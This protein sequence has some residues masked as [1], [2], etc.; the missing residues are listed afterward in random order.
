MRKY[1]IGL[2]VLLILAFA[3][4]SNA[5][6]SSA[7]KE[8]QYEKVKGMVK[9]YLGDEYEAINFRVT[10][11]KFMDEAKTKYQMHYAFD[12]NKPFLFIQNNIPAVME[13]SKAEDKWFCTSNLPSLPNM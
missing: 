13:F 6:P 8:E 4:C 10:E 2:G 9:T 1:L 7:L 5:K 12:L 3:G 11:E